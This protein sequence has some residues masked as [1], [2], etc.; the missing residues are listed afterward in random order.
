MNASKQNL[1]EVEALKRKVKREKSARHQ[2][3]QILE[4]KSTELYHTNQ[5]LK[6]ALAELDERAIAKEKQLVGELRANQD[7]TRT[8][9]D[10]AQEGIF[11]A[12]SNGRLF[13][14][15]RAAEEMFG[16]DGSDVIGADVSILLA[17]P[18]KEQ[19]D[20]SLRSFLHSG[21]GSFLQESRELIAQRADGSHFPIELWV[22]N[23]VSVDGTIFFILIRDLSSQ[24]AAEKAIFEKEVEVQQA[25]DHLAHIARVATLGEIAAGIA[26]EVNQPLAAITTYAQ[27]GHRLLDANVREKDDIAYVLQQIERQASRASEVISRLRSSIKYGDATRERTSINTIIVDTLNLIGVEADRKKVEIDYRPGDDI[28]A[29]DVDSVQIQQVLINLI[30]NAMQAL[31]AANVPHPHVILITEPRAHQ[32]IYVC[33]RD[34]GPPIRKE[35][36][37]QLFTPFFSTKEHGLGIG[38]SLCRTLIAAHGGNLNINRNRHE[39]N[40]FFFTLPTINAAIKTPT[41][42]ESSNG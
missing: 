17:S 24:K 31:E 36:M 10:S 3:E 41:K 33:V 34:N 16:Y 35:T 5:K 12:N 29:I 13:S 4:L 30:V 22:V 14:L 23:T 21:D 40:E 42:T 6:H 32:Q 18:Y 7:T 38:L 8:L 39:G 11:G 28:A 1:A 27:S 25:R 15:N 9:L 19:S 2:A 20:E 37:D 26:H